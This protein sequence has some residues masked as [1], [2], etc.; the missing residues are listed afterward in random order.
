ML[1]RSIRAI[2]AVAVAAGLLALAAGPAAATTPKPVRPGSTYLAL[3]DSVTFG[4]QER[5]VVPAPN[6]ARAASFLGYPEQL[7]RE[8]RLKVVNAACPGETSASLV[9]ASAPSNGCENDY[10]TRFPLHVRYSG[11]Q[12]AFAVK[13]LRK[14]PDTRLVS[15]MVGANDYLLCQKTTS[16]GCTGPAELSATLAKISGNVGRILSAIRHKAH[17]RGQLA[18]VDYYSLNYSVP[19]ISA[20]SAAL[21]ATIHKAARPYH[22]IT[23]DGFRELRVASARSGG[24]NTCTAGLLTQLGRPGSC[25]LHLSYA[26]DALLAQ[27]LL[28]AIRI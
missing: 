13:F 20:Q 25:G 8:L 14:H 4:Y 2:G 23:A 5:T 24:G 27:S 19:A 18:I 7:G 16:D 11:S 15:L 3:G 6:Y 10:R 21:N 26:G 1:V 12:L 9:N 17:Y 28:K 22:V